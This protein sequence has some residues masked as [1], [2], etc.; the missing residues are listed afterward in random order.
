MHPSKCAVAYRLRACLL[1]CFRPAHDRYPTIF[2]AP[3]GDK[4]NPIPFDGDR[5]AKG[6]KAFLRKHSSA[7]IPRSKKSAKKA[8]KVRAACAHQKKVPCWFKPPSSDR[9]PCISS[10]SRRV[11]RMSFNLS[12]IYL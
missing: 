9:L 7:E 10:V 4:E 11:R 3:K 12:C 1:A 2:L 8:E 5:T 6:L